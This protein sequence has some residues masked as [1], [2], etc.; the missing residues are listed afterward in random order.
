MTA[1]R[2]IVLADGDPPTRAALDA[3]WPGWA[4][5]VDL[6]VAADGGARLAAE[7]G[8]PIHAWV[9]DGDS[10]GAVAL[11]G[12]RRA[13]IPTALAPADK[14]ESDAELGV[15]AAIR[16][17][18]GDITIFSGR[19]AARGSIT[20]WRTSPSWPTPLPWASPYASSTGGRGCGCWL[21]PV[22][23]EA[24]LASTSPAG[25]GTSCR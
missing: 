15:L 13:G 5:G 1:H 8:L 25:S 16:A 21:L 17:G 10:L 11:D 4:D 2:A 9:G 3:A 6:V 14:D 20:R 7:L 19:W 12:L 22:P 24:R 18:A 23:M